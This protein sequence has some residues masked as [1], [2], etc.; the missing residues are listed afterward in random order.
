MNSIMV[1]LLIDENIPFIRGILEPHARI[2][3]VPGDKIDRKALHSADGIIIRTRT[4]CDKQLLEGTPVRFIATAT[5]GHDHIDAA[6]CERNG[7]SWYYAEGC[8]A[9]GVQQ[10]IAS[11][12]A[13]LVLKYDLKFKDLTIGIIGVGHVGTKVA[14]LARVLGMKT[15]L[16]DPPRERRE[17]SKG[18]VSLEEILEKSDIITLHVPLELTGRDRTLH[19]AGEAFLRSVRKE[20]TLINTSRGEVVDP[21]ALLRSLRSKRL[22]AAVVDVWE[23]EPRIDRQLLKQVSLATPHIAGYS[24]EGKANGAAMCVRAASRYF[25]FGIDNWSPANLPL[26]SESLIRTEAHGRQAEDLFPSVALKVYDITRDDEALRADPGGFETI[27]NHYPVRREF[28]A[29]HLHVSGAEK[30]TV[31]MFKGLGFRVD[32]T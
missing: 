8:N 28:G 1:R 14:H 17:G 24:T 26:P 4:R 12:L 25:G 19:L 29:Y 22:L 11:A 16:N 15:L 27:R 32:A 2:S 20:A 6:Y 3:Y 10:Y 13:S 9:S 23:G 7:I 21:H 31:E 5:I 30:E 18:F